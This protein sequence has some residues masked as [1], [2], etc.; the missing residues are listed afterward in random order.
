MTLQEK[1]DA[2]RA[3]TAEKVPPETLKVMK[4]S[5]EALVQ[6]GIAKKALKTGDRAP[7]F[8]LNNVSD[9][10]VNSADIL[11]K[12]PMVLTFYRGAW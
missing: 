10:A 3:A 5:T 6:S 9:I 1:M 12:G 8:E 4:R 2:A 11:K 7:S